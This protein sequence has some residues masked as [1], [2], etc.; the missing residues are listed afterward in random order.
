M[1]VTSIFFFSDNVFYPSQNKFQNK[2]LF[3][4]TV[5]LSSANAVDLD[6]A[7]YLSFGKELSLSGL[8]TTLRKKT[9]EQIMGKEE[10]N[11]NQHFLLFP[12][13]VF[14]TSQ[15]VFIFLVMFIF[16]SS[17]ALNLDDS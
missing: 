8:L 17:Y 1:L 16:L 12:Q 7:K 14:Y 11:C 15:K 13:C 3:L 2:F 6:Q 9:F 4:V 10:N 5:I